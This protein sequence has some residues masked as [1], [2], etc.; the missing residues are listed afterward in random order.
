VVFTELLDFSGDE[1][2]FQEEKKLTGKTFVEAMFSYD[3]STVIGL[4]KKSGE[5]IIRPPFDTV[6]AEGDK[7]IAISEDDD[8]VVLSGI[9]NYKVDNSSLVINT[10]Y[11]P[12]PPETTLI[13]GWNRRGHLIV[14]ELDKYVAPGSKI[15][16]LSYHSETDADVRENC[17][18]TK[19]AKLNT[20]YGDTANRKILDKLNIQ[21]Y[22]HIIVLSQ[23]EKYG[24][25]SSDAK[26]LSTLLH[27]RDI[28]DHTEHSY[29][30]VSEMLD[31]RNRELAEIT[32]TDDF[33]VSV[34]LDSL[35]L[36]QISENRELKHIFE[37]LFSSGGPAIYIRPVEEY[38]QL[39]R[40]VNFYT[41]V[42]A[43]RQHNE[44]AI[45][46]KLQ[47]KEKLSSEEVMLAH[48]VV[49]NPIKSHELFFAKGDKLIILGLDQTYQE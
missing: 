35:M 49:V 2:Y 4:R 12:Q 8:T 33:I 7:I 15:D 14:N 40:A 36:T 5:I 45:G 43:A 11:Q 34:K 21:N 26:T 24:I 42:E 3:T 30:I 32:H 9:K 37:S 48:G 23:E 13:I 10:D 39:D 16:I 19:N 29:S 1:I 44:I 38:V 18:D 6:I 28:G 25:Q 41:V 47:N 22:D 27:I 46:Y 31:D 20:F 17:S